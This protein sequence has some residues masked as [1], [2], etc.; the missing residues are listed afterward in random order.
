MSTAR[1]ATSDEWPQAAKGLSTANKVLLPIAIILLVV[2]LYK[3]NAVQSLREFQERQDVQVDKIKEAC[4]WMRS[5]TAKYTGDYSNYACEEAL[6]EGKSVGVV[7]QIC[8][9]PY[10]L[11]MATLDYGNDKLN[12]LYQRE[13]NTEPPSEAE[14]N[15]ELA[16]DKL[17]RLKAD[18]YIIPACNSIEKLESQGCKNAQAMFNSKFKAV[19]CY[20]NL[21][22]SFAT[23]AVYSKDIYD[24]KWHYTHSGF[25][26][27]ANEEC[28]W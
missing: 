15:C 17:E 16:T 3:Y 13:L 2:A 9:T 6:N 28:T 27:H 1:S 4:D 23:Y 24:N 26:I 22:K 10:Y 8:E 20:N 12:F 19:L 7:G 5:K 21:T 11:H 18:A 14:D 25:D